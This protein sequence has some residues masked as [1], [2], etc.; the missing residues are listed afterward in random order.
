MKTFLILALAASALSCAAQAAEPAKAG[1]HFS[2]AGKRPTFKEQYVKPEVVFSSVQTAGR[3]S[4]FDEIWEPQFQAPPHL[5]KK[6][7]ETFYVISGKVEWTVN[8]EAHVLGAGDAVHIPPGAVHSTRVVGDQ[9]MRILMI[10]EPGGFEESL[11]YEAS[12]TAEEL[13]DPKL[14]AMLN[15]V[16]DFHPAQHP[17]AN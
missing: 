6:H 2:F 16:A 9:P 4:M 17:K 15:D 11:A 8:G 13:K 12:F 14:R 7:A 10:S 3:L 5:H 1:H